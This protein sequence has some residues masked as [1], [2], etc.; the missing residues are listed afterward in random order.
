MHC[1][2]GEIGRRARFRFWYLNDV[3]VQVPPPAPVS[4]KSDT[5]LFRHRPEQQDKDTMK[6]TE[7]LNEGLNR[8]YEILLT[9]AE[10]DEKAATKLTEIAATASIPGF[11]PGKVPMSVVKGRFGEQ[12]KGDVIRT[13]LDDSAKDAIESHGLKLASQ[14]KLDIVSFED[15]ADLTATLQC[16]VM[17]EITLPDL[18]ALSITRPTLPSNESEI[19]ETM[20]RLADENRPSIL[21]EKKRKAKMGDIVKMDFTGRVDG[22]A[23]EGGTAEGH[24]LE[25]GS[26]S[27]I[28]GFEE[29]LVGASA[30][31]TVDVTVTFPE[32]YQ[33]E[34]LAGKEAV[35]ECV[36]HELHEK[37][38][39]SLDDALATKLGFEKLSDL[40]DAVA[41]QLASQ[42]EQGLRQE[43]KKNILD[44]LAEDASF[45]VPESLYQS[46]YNT[47]AR[48][49][50]PPEQQD[51]PEQDDDQNHVG[52][53]ALDDAQKSEASDI[54][55]RRVRLGLML[56]EIG[57]Q[58]N[59]QVT[60]EDTRRAV[61]DQARRYPGQEQQVMEYYQ[62]NQ[63]AM[64]QL[65][66]PV[67]EEKVIDFILE[68]AKVT[69]VE[70]TVE[71]LYAEPDTITAK[72]AKKAAAKKSAAKKSATKKEAAPKKAAPKKSA[73]KKASAKK[74]ATKK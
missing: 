58:N 45:E 73:A 19:D 67:F 48:S 23:F 28:P 16:E 49:M 43:V 54:A 29:G 41:G 21:V 32:E 53:E 44:A 60:E 5:D 70:T 1:G 8:S 9:A 51:N 20:T 59:I 26:N 11:R 31:E 17:P 42:H 12:V 39:A 24:M 15:G 57:Q 18:S 74:A 27:F 13:S 40:R 61:I 47:V 36:V 71:A 4:E 69:D 37:G 50:T 72:P 55:Y 66:G 52:D 62:N 22:T 3:G 63:D 34:H 46:E 56:T 14:P 35:F 33:A 64:Q 7:T 30:G 2:R 25:L 6:I 38:E 68:M 65:A 10:M